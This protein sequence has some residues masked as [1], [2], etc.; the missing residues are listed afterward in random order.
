MYRMKKNIPFITTLLFTAVL[1]IGISYAAW[2]TPSVVPPSNN[3]ASPVTALPVS[4]VKNGD[5]SVNTFAALGNGSFKQRVLFNGTILALDPSTNTPTFRIG[6][7]N[8]AGA[9][10]SVNT[11]VSHDVV[12]QE[13]IG[14]SKLKNTTLSPLCSDGSGN[15]VLCGSAPV[16]PRVGTAVSSMCDACTVLYVASPATSIRPGASVYTDQNLTTPYS[17][18]TIGDQNGTVYLLNGNQVSTS[19]VSSCS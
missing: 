16:A 12:S 3:I 2:N 8:S 17:N 15:V 5:L 9:T 10:V 13:T 1:S 14:S 19:T 6:G 7:I 11:T 18:T 4:Q